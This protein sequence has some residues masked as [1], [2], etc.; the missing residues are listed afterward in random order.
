MTFPAETGYSRLY[1]SLTNPNYLVLRSRRKI[2]AGWFNQLGD[3]P[4]RILDVGSRYQPY[5]PLLG[6]KVERYVG[7]DVETEGQVAVVGDGQALPFA[8]RSFDLVIACGVFEFFQDPYVAAGEIH[9]VLVPGGV[10][11]A[12]LSAFAPL[13]ALQER[14]RFLPEGIR[15]VFKGFRSIEVV[16][17]LHDLGSF[18][19]IAG[20]GLNLIF[21]F[22]GGREIYRSTLC[23]LLNLAGLAFEGLNMTSTDQLTCNY[24]IRVVK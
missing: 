2:F 6:H 20:G 13:F 7:L 4:L 14:W 17:E 10:L 11:I 16:P 21:R 1:P 23:P 15:G 3:R 18:F 22:R 19:R 9:N 24:S 12:S 5:R 8:P